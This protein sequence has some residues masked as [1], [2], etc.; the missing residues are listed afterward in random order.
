MRWAE[1][2]SAFSAG[3]MDLRHLALV[4]GPKGHGPLSLRSSRIR[5][6]DPLAADF[7]KKIRKIKGCTF[8]QL[9]RL[10]MPFEALNLTLFPMV[11]SECSPCWQA[12]CLTPNRVVEMEA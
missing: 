11:R 2:S 1:G 6:D 5:T 3:L 8:A 9:G 12:F 7:R 10:F 4:S